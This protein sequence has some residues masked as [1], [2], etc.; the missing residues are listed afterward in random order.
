ML[1]PDPNCPITGTLPVRQICHIKSCPCAP[2]S[3]LFQYPTPEPLCESKSQP[4]PCPT[5]ER[6]Q[7]EIQSKSQAVS[8]DLPYILSR[9]CLPPYPIKLFHKTSPPLH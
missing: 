1:L 3:P 9:L 8:R 5:V 4:T 2:L 7:S 6:T